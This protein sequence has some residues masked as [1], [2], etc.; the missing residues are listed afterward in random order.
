MAGYHFYR[1]NGKEAAS[2]VYLYR[3]MM[4]SLKDRKV[5]TFSSKMMLLR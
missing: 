4:K 5:R 3:I 2:G 1:W